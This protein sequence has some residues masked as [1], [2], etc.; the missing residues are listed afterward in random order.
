MNEMQKSI[1]LL[2]ILLPF[3]HSELSF[4]PFE[5]PKVWTIY[6]VTLMSIGSYLYKMKSEVRPS[7][8]S[9]ILIAL[10]SLWVWLV[11]TSYINGNFWQSW[12]GNYYRLDGLLT[13]TAVMLI[14]LSLRP[15]K[16]LWWG[17]G[18]GSVVLSGLS[19]WF[20]GESSLFFGNPNLLAGYLAVTLPITNILG[21]FWVVPQIGA[22][23]ML[24]SWGGVLVALLFI[25]F[26]VAKNKP[27]L[28]VMSAVLV[29]LGLGW[30]YQIEQVRLNPQNIVV[31]EGR[32]R[33][34]KKAIIAIEKKPII[35]WGWAQFGRAFKTIDWPVPY[36]ADVHV[37]RT[38]ASITEYAVAGGIPALSLFIFIV[39]TSVGV[40]LKDKQMHSQVLGLV[41]V[42]YL[43]YSQTNVTSVA[44]EWLFYL[45]IGEAISLQL[46]ANLTEMI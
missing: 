43:I 3:V 7:K 13:L 31:A 45:A 33:I 39:F 23:V 30:L 37:D 24:K 14:A 5:I 4:S 41:L 9:S 11:I 2:L 17:M 28:L 25:L 29:C 27:K 22:I 35:G 32:E 40:L 16:F 18:V 12:L 38:H 36:S 1:I 26:I 10:S 42:L 34:W 21:I 8:G 15:R 46:K 20:G 44:V 6:L 19:I